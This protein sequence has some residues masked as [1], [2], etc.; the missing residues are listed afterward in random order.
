MVFGKGNPDAQIMFIGEAPGEKEDLAGIPF[1]GK[2][3]KDL[4]KQLN[5]ISLTLDDVYIA[6]ILKYRPPKNRNPKPEEMI[7]HTPYLVEQIKKIICTLGNF[8]T[9]FILANANIKE[10]KKIQGVDILHGKTQE[11]TFQNLKIKVFPIHHPSSIIYS[12]DRRKW[13]SEDFKTIA[14]ILGKKIKKEKEE[15]QKTLI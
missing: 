2:A 7:N 14:N 13:F 5:T 11:I 3:G 6:N 12:K 8:A 1:V 9:K 10:M 4:D 15:I